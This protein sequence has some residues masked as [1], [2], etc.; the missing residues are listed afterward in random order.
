MRLE[1]HQ[2]TQASPQ[3]AGKHIRCSVMYEGMELK[4]LIFAYG[5]W[6][7]SS[8]SKVIY[9]LCYCVFSSCSVFLTAMNSSKNRFVLSSHLCS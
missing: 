6:N 4:N 3:G 8:P 2:M 9:V 1:R 7:Q 5:V